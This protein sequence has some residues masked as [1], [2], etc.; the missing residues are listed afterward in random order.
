MC[1]ISG[2]TRSRDR[3]P[4]SSRGEDRHQRQ[5]LGVVERGERNP[6]LKSPLKIAQALGVEPHELLIVGQEEPSALKLR[7]MSQ[8]LLQ[9]EDREELQLAYKLLKALVR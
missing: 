9:E 1:T 4:G 5:Y 2:Y 3:D 6:L 7:A 8:D